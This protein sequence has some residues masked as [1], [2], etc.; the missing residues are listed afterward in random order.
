MTAVKE[1]RPSRPKVRDLA[2]THRSRRGV[3]QAPSRVFLSFMIVMGCSPGDQS[4]DHSLMLNRAVP[5]WTLGPEPEFI[6]GDRGA[7][8]TLFGSVLAFR[9]PNGDLLA[10]DAGSSEL[11]VFRGHDSPTVL[12]RQ[13]QGP[14]ELHGRFTVALAGDTIV[15][16]GSL[17]SRF[18]V[19]V[20]TASTGHL[21]RFRL[22]FPFE[23]RGFGPVAW[24]RSG[25]F[26]VQEAAGGRVLREPPPQGHLIADSTTLA[27]FHPDEDG[28]M[29]EVRILGRFLRRW[30]Y[31]HRWP[32]G[33]LPTAL[34]PY[35][36]GASTH[37]AVS[38]DLLWLGDAE[39]GVITGFDSMATKV[40]VGS[41]PVGFRRFN[42][43]EVEGARRT[44]MAG[45]QTDYERAQ[46]AAM[47]DPNLL[48]ATMPL[49]NGMIGGHAGEVWIRM[50]ALGAADHDDYLVLDRSGSVI[51]QVKVPRGLRITQVQQGTLLGVREDAEG[52]EQIVEYQLIRAP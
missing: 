34:S 8:H 10:A 17:D 30:H 47:Y 48:P 23:M 46:V 20:F 38:G 41:L 37:W 43:R 42:L 49:F 9:L 13:G 44:A 4:A 52:V 32:G 45:A 7:T 24:L 1:L 50:F 11:R 26:L 19:N 51:G 14:G 12:A 36:F 31:V 39:S 6:L 35:P 15:V 5:R 28:A 21:A 22:Q 27:L 33:P 2:L 16:I 40:V 25:A 29:V 18:M 3:I